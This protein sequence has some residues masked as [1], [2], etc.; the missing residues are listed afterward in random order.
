MEVRASVSFFPR[1][2][3]ILHPSTFIL[4]PFTLPRSPY[5]RA[6]DLLAARAYTEREL[7]RKLTQK[8]VPVAEVDAV[9]D[10]L[11]ESG[12]VDDA[13]YA[14]QFARSRLAGGGATWRVRQELSRKGVSGE[15]AGAA[16]EQ[17]LEEEDID[18][19]ATLE[20]VA[21]KKLVSMGDLEPLVLRRRVYGFLARRGHDVDEINV[22]MKSI[23]RN[24][25]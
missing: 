22:V 7:R 13:R 19:A 16:I 17:V 21:R 10:R 9:L 2:P 8:E 4:H 6:L 3:F 18:T 5:A 15:V 11:R 1:Y 23:F 20:R 14:A 25:S 12:L 24:D